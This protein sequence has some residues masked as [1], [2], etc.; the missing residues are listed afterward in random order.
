MS[1]AKNLISFDELESSGHPLFINTDERPDWPRIFENDH[2]LKLEI[3]FGNGRFLI[4]LALQRQ[5]S[6]LIG[7]DFY[8]KGIRKSVTRLDKLMIN[9]ARICYGDARQKVPV[10]FQAGELSEI[11]INFPDPWP[12]K[13]H[14]KRRLIKPDFVHLLATLLEPG[15]TLRLAT[16]SEPYAREM[17]VYLENEPLL[18]NKS[19]ETQFF[20]ERSDVPKTKYENYFIRNGHTIYY[21]DF[22]KE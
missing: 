21:T 14:I 20:H 7:L 16:D 3:G 8:H 10:L 5:E 13:R 17:I 18:K 15:G 2:P 6:N 9:N 11:F 22:I 19:G 1:S 4:E 12:K